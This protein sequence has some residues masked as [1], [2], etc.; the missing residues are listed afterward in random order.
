MTTPNMEPTPTRKGI[1]LGLAAVALAAFFVV[2]HVLALPAK[3]RYPGELNFIEG[4]VMVEMIHLRQGVPIYAPPSAQGYDAANFGPLYYMVGARLVDPQKPAYLPLRVLSLLGVLVCAVVASLM[5]FRLSRNWLAALLAPLLFLS[6]GLVFRHGASARS[7]MV[8]LFLVFTGFTVA[9]RFRTSRALLLAVP[10]MLGGF[11]YKQQ[12]V[13]GPLAVLIFL[14]LEKRFRLAAEF[15]GLMVLG[16]LAFLAVIQYVIFPGQAFL[17][18]FVLYN[19]LPFTEESL[20]LGIGFF[21]LIL[22][23]PLLVSLEFL[24][25]CP[26]RLVKCYL[27]CAFTLSMLTVARAGSDTYYFLECVLVSSILFAALLAKRI[28]EPARAVE[29]LVLLIVTLFVGQWFRASSPSTEDFRQDK[30]VQDYLQQ[31]FPPG[32]PA[33]SYYAGD[34]VRAGLALPFTNLYHYN[35][36]IRKGVVS[37][38]DMTGLLAKHHF[39]AVVLDFDLE[40]EGVNYYTEYYLTQTIRSAIQVN[41][42]LA[43]VLEMPGPEKLREEAKF[44]VWVPRTPAEGKSQSAAL[45]R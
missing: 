35:Q 6:Y 44:Y 18:H 17:R 14:L 42:Q 38:R 32:T 43:T 39:G 11:Y 31:H 41:Y 22:L 8:A 7:D 29:L 28:V 2:I 15:T 23:V 19:L 21:A 3:L 10:F 26:D 34:I 1:L 30:A 4:Q 13:A 37:D 9:H 12:F 40:K 24:R 36:L 25:A 20:L 45:A 5:A 16:G 27:V 33:L